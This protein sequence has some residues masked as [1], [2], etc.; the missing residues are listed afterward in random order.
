M[1]LDNLDLQVAL[2]FPIK[3][4]VNWPFRLRR[5]KIEID[6]QDGRRVIHLGFPVVIILSIFDVQVTLMLPTSQLAFQLI[7][8]RSK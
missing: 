8:Q 6:F 4:R 2:I 3:F 5:K 1:I 7:G